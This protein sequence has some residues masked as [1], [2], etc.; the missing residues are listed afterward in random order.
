MG[1]LEQWG[2]DYSDNF[3]GWR[4]QEYYPNNLVQVH[5]AFTTIQPYFKPVFQL[6][7]TQVPEGGRERVRE[8]VFVCEREKTVKRR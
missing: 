8:S 1:V 6:G 2:F 3:I 4:K 5:P 7:H